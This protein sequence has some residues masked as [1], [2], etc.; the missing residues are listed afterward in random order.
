M[1]KIKTAFQFELK[2]AEQKL[3]KSFLWIVGKYPNNQK[4]IYLLGSKSLR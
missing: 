2:Y 1:K 3:E 4:R